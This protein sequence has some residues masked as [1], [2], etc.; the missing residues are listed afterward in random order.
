MYRLNNSLRVI[1]LVIC[2]FACTSIAQGGGVTFV[3]GRD[4]TAANSS[5]RSLSS[6]VQG[7][8]ITPG[9]NLP[10]N[11]NVTPYINDAPSGN[12]SPSVP[13]WVSLL[14]LLY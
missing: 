14:A 11:F 9:G 5:T 3:G 12:F 6:G 1:T 10:A 8:Q 7:D 2:T 4:G 13:M